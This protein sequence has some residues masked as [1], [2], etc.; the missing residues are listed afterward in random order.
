MF[1]KF[2]NVCGREYLYSY[3]S[4]HKLVEAQDCQIPSLVPGLLFTFLFEA[5]LNEPGAH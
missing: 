4:L 3:E 1:L 2:E 5:G